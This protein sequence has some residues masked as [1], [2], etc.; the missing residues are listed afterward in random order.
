MNLDNKTIRAALASTLSWPK[1]KAAIAV[2]SAVELAEAEHLEKLGKR[3]VNTLMALKAERH[4]R[5]GRK[6]KMHQLKVEAKL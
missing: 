1:M 4:T 2:L 6:A 5:E 3:R